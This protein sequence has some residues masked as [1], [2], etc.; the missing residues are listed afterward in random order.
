MNDL[1]RN[2]GGEISSSRFAWI[3]PLPP[4]HT[5]IARYSQRVL[6]GLHAKEVIRVVPEPVAGITTATVKSVVD[7]IL[8]EGT[9]PIC[10][11]GN[12][13]RF[14]ALAF[15]VCRFLPSVIILHDRMLQNFFVEESLAKTNDLQLYAERMSESYGVDVNELMQDLKTSSTDTELWESPKIMRMFPLVEA[16]GDRCLLAI[17][18]NS[19]IVDELK[20]RIAAPV[21][22]VPFPH[23]CCVKAHRSRLKHDG[24]IQL[25]QFG[26]I[27]KNR[28]LWQVLDAIASYKHRK[29]LRLDVYGTICEEQEAVARVARLGLGEFVRFHGFVPDDVLDQALVDADLVINLRNPTAGEASASQL[30]AFDAAVASVVTNESWYATL[31]DD[32]VIRIEPGNE[33][34]GLQRAFDRLIKAPGSIRCMGD[35]GRRYLKANHPTGKLIETLETIGSLLPDLRKR[36]GVKLMALRAAERAN[37]L[38]LDPKIATRQI[39]RQVHRFDEVRRRLQHISGPLADSVDLT[40]ERSGTSVPERI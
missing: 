26:F 25:V 4:T 27:G 39:M 23:D 31:P 29:R 28:C 2:G 40:N 35:A 34:R 6:D 18:H 16:I 24:I 12:N 36:C 8:S 22:Y 3:S 38:G 11:I 20:H 5:E 10:N 9:I 30:R 7:K 21:V 1:Q 33:I 37:Q 14:H 17:T 32:T 19:A 15:E 13:Y